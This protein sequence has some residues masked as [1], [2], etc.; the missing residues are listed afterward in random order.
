MQEICQ[1]LEDMEQ[2]PKLECWRAAVYLSKGLFLGGGTD[3]DFYL[4]S[5]AFG[6]TSK[7]FSHNNNNAYKYKYNL[8]LFLTL[9]N[10]YKIYK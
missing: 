5:C 9:I 4:G 1:S 7:I 3:L 8:Y 10:K 2:R 6:L